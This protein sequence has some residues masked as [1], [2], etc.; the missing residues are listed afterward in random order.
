MNAKTDQRG[1]RLRPVRI[2]PSILSADFARLRDEIRDVERAGADLLHV[3]VMDGHFVPN[4][5]FGPPV[6]ECLRATTDLYLDVHLMVERP[7]RLLEAFIDAGSDRITI[8]VEATERP[9]EILEALRARGKGAGI[10]LRPGTPVARVL[11]LLDAADLL[12]IMTVEPGFGGQAFMPE[13][14]E[15]IAPALEVRERLGQERFWIQVDGG[16][17]EETVGRARAAGAEV[18]V[19]GSAVFGRPD[20]AEACARLRALAAEEGERVAEE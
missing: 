1:R 8:H 5:T 9:R 15:K 16:I 6:V 14:L 10:T 18:F 4:I 20:R 3:D 13:N 11:P 17:G 7:E 2:A 12:L 19:A